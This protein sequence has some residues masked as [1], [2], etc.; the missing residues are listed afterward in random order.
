MGVAIG[1]GAACALLIAII[2]TCLVMKKRRRNSMFAS[3]SNL[4][5]GDE[6]S[7]VQV[8]IDGPE[9]GEPFIDNC[10][11]LAGSDDAH[12]FRGERVLRLGLL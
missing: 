8:S 9:A 10:T 4:S 12:H 6:L 5:G 3:R 7:A 2:V 1:V 11:E